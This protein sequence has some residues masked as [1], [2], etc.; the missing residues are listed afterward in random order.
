MALIYQTPSSFSSVSKKNKLVNKVKK[1]KILCHFNPFNFNPFNSN[2]SRNS[3]RRRPL[4]RI[5]SKKETG[6]VVKYADFFLNFASLF[7]SLCLRQWIEYRLTNETF[8]SIC[9]GIFF[10]FIYQN[11]SFRFF[12]T[13]YLLLQDILRYFEIFKVP[14]EKKTFQKS[15][16]A[17]Y[18]FAKFETLFLFSRLHADL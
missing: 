9:F 1:K 7:Y 18:N 3:Y 12:L 15:W 13:V 5:N 8:V 11:F 4:L 10:L 14:S 2:V 17:M 6:N 16:N